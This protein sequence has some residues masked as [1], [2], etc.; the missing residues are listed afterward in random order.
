VPGIQ[1]RGAILDIFEQASVGSKG[2]TF[3]DAGELT[4]VKVYTDEAM[5]ALVFTKD[6]AYN[7]AGEL[8]TVTLTREGDGA[9]WRKTFSYNDDGELVDV[10]VAPLP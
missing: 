3:N 7:G 10:T 5:T 6:F 4:Q 8:I 9:Q 1:T 2:F